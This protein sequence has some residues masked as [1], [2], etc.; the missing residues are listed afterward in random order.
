MERLQRTVGSGDGR[1]YIGW[2]LRTMGRVRES[3]EETERA[4]RLEA[5]DPMTANLVALA[6]M[7][8]GRVAEAVPVYEELVARVPGMSFPVSSLLRAY[9]FQQD[10]AA[11]D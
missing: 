2:C 1:R 8:A 9:P 7:A 6:R 3:L 4:Y 11:V 5:L 10:W